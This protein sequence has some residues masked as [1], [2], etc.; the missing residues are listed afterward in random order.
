[1]SAYSAA[2]VAVLRR[3]GSTA[4]AGV[5][6]DRH[7][8]LTCAH[9]VNE[10]LGR[11]LFDREVPRGE[12]LVVS[13][14]IADGTATYETAIVEDGW[15]AP[16]E[17]PSF[18]EPEDIA[19]LASRGGAGFASNVRAARLL[20]VDLQ[21]EHD[22]KVWLTGFPGGG[23]SDR[24]P[25]LV[26]GI[27]SQGR[28]QI[29][30]LNHTRVVSEGFSGAGIW[31]ERCGGIIGILVAKR[32]RGVATIAY[33]LPL[34]VVA[35]AVDLPLEV[36][37]PSRLPALPPLPRHFV[38]RD[39]LLAPLRTCLLEGR[40]TAKG[41]G[42]PLALLGMGGLGKTVLASA[43]LQDPDVVAAFGP[44]RYWIAVGQQR[45]PTSAQVELLRELTGKNVVVE[46]LSDGRKQLSNA[47]ADR[48]SLIIVDDLWTTDQAAAFEGIGGRAL[49]VVTTRQST[50][51]QRLGAREVQMALL[52]QEQGRALLAGWSG[53]EMASLP[54]TADA[55]IAECGGLPLALATFGA[56][57]AQSD[58]SW[59]EGLEAL[60][61]RDLGDLARPIEGY[62]GNE[63]VFGAI[64]LSF[65]AL[66]E[67]DQAAFAR[68]AVLPEDWP[69]PPSALEALWYD[70]PGL[71]GNAR[72]LR[73]LCQR[74]DGA[75]LWRRET[76]S[77]GV[78]CFRLHDLVVDFLHAKLDRPAAAHKAIVEGYRNK[79]PQGWSSWQ[80]DDGYFLEG[81]PRHLAEAGL[82]DELCGLLFDLDWLRR[83]LTA[84]HPLALVNDTALCPKEADVR[85]LG[86]ALQL[87]AHVIGHD[88]SQLEA[89]LLGRLDRGDGPQ[90]A[91]LLEAARRD[92]SPGVLVPRGG[93][94]LVPP[95]PLLRILEGHRG[96]MNGAC[97]LPDGRILS[98]AREN[99]LLLW[100]L[101]A[102]TSRSLQ[103]H[104][105]EVEGAIAV[106]GNRALS[107]SFD[108]PPRLWDLDGGSSRPLEGF[109]GSLAGVLLLPDDSVLSWSSD[110]ALRL[111]DLESGTCRVLEGHSG[112]VAGALLL[113][114]GR[115]LSWASSWSIDKSPRLW[116][117]ESGTSQCLEGFNGPISGA[118]VL[119]DARVLAWD[120]EGTLC[121]LDLDAGASR[122]L[123]GHRD[124]VVGLLPLPDARALSWASDDS[125]LLWDLAAGTSQTL[126]EPQEG[127]DA[128]VLFRLQDRGA[129][130]LPGDRAI[131]WAQSQDLHLWDLKRG[132]K[133]VL[134]GHSAS[135]KGALLL[136]DGRALSWAS[137]GTLR[138]WDPD[139]GT[140][141]VFEGHSGAVEGALLLPDGRALS[142]SYDH[143]LCLWD[144]D[145]EPLGKPQI[146]HSRGV[147]G[148]LR[149]SG[150]RALTWGGQSLR[151]WDLEDGS[152]HALEGHS[153]NVMGA[154]SL[155]EKQVLSW[156]FDSSLR[157]WDLDNG[158]DR[159]F[160]GHT[161]GVNGALTL[162]GNRALSWSYDHTLRVWQLTTGESQILTG[163]AGLVS[164]A[165]ALPGDRVVSWDFAHQMLR[166]DASTF[167]LWD[168]KAG[169]A[170]VL[171]GH[172]GAV[173]GALLLPHGRVLSWG[174]DHTLRLWD[175][176]KGTSGALKGHSAAV[177]GALL[178]SD[179]SALSWAADGSL[180]RWT[181][182]NG[183]STDLAGH[184][185]EVSGALPL[186][187]NRVLSWAGDHTL[188]LWDLD[189]GTNFPLTGH[190][191]AVNGALL[192]PGER[193]LSWAQDRTLRLWTLQTGE[194]VAC[195]VF[196]A[197]VTTCLLDPS[198][199]IAVA[200]DSNGR[201]LFFNLP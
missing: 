195:A 113:A 200:G 98:W 52:D 146:T 38:S 49:V 115:V 112:P 182:S 28:I 15:I 125:L 75:S 76:D 140:S 105:G 24:I 43:L 47:L 85:R 70:L 196:D 66:S 60:Q 51:V 7:R 133:R 163:H 198:R 142:W 193:A 108:E 21:D 181:L 131:Y 31:D 11:G 27:N 2:I 135:V 180:R 106:P 92:L 74:L 170:R 160:E 57:I 186:P 107:W 161:S 55:V 40:P 117:L 124:A 188:R 130:A 151:I 58:M 169:T 134:E 139:S 50:V 36:I 86:R 145:A 80:Q 22:R 174:F 101:E 119:P 6:L 100:D 5:V 89:Q 67:G 90:I 114:D 126:E 44:E 104:S 18:G 147:A 143:T 63:G 137:D 34:A 118:T 96:V 177:T 48:P 23:T 88:V 167:R 17:D 68:C 73:R 20:D 61:D 4:G 132:T 187:G 81:L 46:S 32:R 110:N 166:S 93:R 157:L 33:G 189:S 164:G 149:L 199:H 78:Q 95:G 201:V 185:A 16:Q 138:L 10:A 148:A 168:L 111:W 144:L 162:P 178:L 156:A 42:P 13:Q 77:S 84:R 71:G 197:P 190:S 3:D 192:L 82:A 94:H 97:V 175:L 91:V 102:G 37:D 136:P 56:A 127:E 159:T 158:S 171:E 12:S 69:I 65:S 8:V 153:G 53:L 62:H 165:L 154:L 103:G 14:L 79:C 121:L 1:M 54:D 64:S 155:S 72:A 35:R 129:L 87:S 172:D 99:N 19:V 45:S 29:D 128:Q 176:D 150:G 83:K 152:S 30:P 41:R 122:F 194:Q 191:A 141:R 173:A 39:A 9:V 184:N 25:G 183:K 120:G 109:T 123:E 26:R 179:G 59:K 116:N